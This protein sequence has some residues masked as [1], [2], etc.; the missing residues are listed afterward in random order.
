[1]TKVVG[2]F[3]AAGI[4]LVLIL[5]FSQGFDATGVVL[6]A[7]ILGVGALSIAVT[8]K[9]DRGAIAPGRCENCGG[10][11]SRNAPFCKHCGEAVA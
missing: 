6:L 1:M 4:T 2:A 10:L 8:R 3:V 9:S 5:G 7:L 11:I